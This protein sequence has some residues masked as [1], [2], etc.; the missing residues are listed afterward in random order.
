MNL[1]A[2][3]DRPEAFAGADDDWRSVIQAATTEEQIVSATRDY[4]ASWG[5]EDIIRLPLDCRPA[6]RIKDGEDISQWAFRLASAH[7]AAEMDLDNEPMLLKMLVF[8]TQAA[9][10]L[11]EVNAARA[12]LP[13]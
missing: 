2:S 1:E 5:P 13:E 7:C 12:D 6:R 9:I 11:S 3:R 10:R 8:V 4:L